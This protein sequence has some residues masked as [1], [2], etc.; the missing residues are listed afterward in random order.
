MFKILLL[1]LFGLCAEE[2]I[3]NSFENFG[4]PAREICPLGE[5]MTESTFLVDGSYVVKLYGSE[6][7][8]LKCS[9]AYHLAFEIGVAPRIHHLD[10]KE[11]VIIMQYIRPQ[12]E[13]DIQ[14]AL[15]LLKKFHRPLENEPFATIH[16]RIR[17]IEEL[18]FD[19]FQEAEER[20]YTIEEGIP[21][22]ITLCHFDFHKGNMITAERTYL[23]DFDDVGYG[24]PYYDLAKFTLLDKRFTP[25]EILSI[26]LER[27]P[28]D[29]ELGVL[30]K[31]IKVAHLSSATNRFLRF[32]KGGP[33]C[34]QQEAYSALS[35]FLDD[36]P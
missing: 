34:L 16:K 27:E 28:E 19:L 25:K 11:F 31:M 22:L 21:R 13:P 17:Q 1:T 10:F 30:R 24:H 36:S 33:H 5:G 23:I 12:E 14:E 9:E 18:G 8:F 29:E 4:V 2:R 3:K 6:S 7:E 35:L 32:L 15:S 26:Y 20:L